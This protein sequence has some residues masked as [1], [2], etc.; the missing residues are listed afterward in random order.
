MKVQA[1][2]EFILI[3][4]AIAV[5]SLSAISM[6]GKNLGVQRTL[7]DA[8]SN[9][10]QPA[11]VQVPLPDIAADPQVAVYVPVNSTVYASS[12]L[13]ATA[14]GCTY[15]TVNLTLSSPSVFFSRS[16]S[17]AKMFG[18]AVLSM[19]FEPLA[20][21]P[22]TIGVRYD[23]SCGNVTKSGYESLSTY[24][25]APSSG[26]A[27]GATYSA[28]ISDRSEKIEYGLAPPSQVINL[29]EWNHCTHSNFWGTPLPTSSQCG[30]SAWDYMVFSG[31][32]YYTAQVST[33]STY[34]I[35]PV[36]TGYS[37]V[38]I[39]GATGQEYSFSLAISSPFGTM[40][41]ALNGSGESRLTLENETVG[42]AV[43]A[44]VSAPGQSQDATLISSGGGYAM[45]NQTALSQYLQAENNLYG[46][47][48]YY[49]STSVDSS[50]QSSI[51][52]AASTFRGASGNLRSSESGG[53]P[54][55]V[56]AGSYV[57]DSNSPFTY[58]IEVNMSRGLLAENQTLYYL[59]S[60][61][62]LFRG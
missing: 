5:L 36:P 34:C 4:S 54:C 40:R 55:N 15:G 35:A 25:S 17:S 60:E 56:S 30:A 49:N 23:I 39:G 47:L 59:G 53:V 52:Q 6:Y 37:T 32:C 20:Q 22:D 31:Y 44:N 43:V 19:A 11:P 27:P 14:Y 13:Q 12:S 3:T 62:N 1:S 58:V 8:A 7:L 16:S 28:Y 50:T 24:A 57:C 51:E 33:T 29:T 21:G 61:I 10:M 41:A 9:A 26:G 46:T 42:Y 45:A 38:A 2:L 18:A 48:A